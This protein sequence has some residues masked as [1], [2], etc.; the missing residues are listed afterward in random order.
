MSN[1]DY[2]KIIDIYSIEQDGSYICN[3]C[4]IS[5]DTTEILDVEEFAKGEDGGVVK[6]REVK[7]FQ[8]LK[9]KKNI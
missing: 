9:N 7:I 6:T 5:I 8:S 4:N 2:N 3:A 1:I